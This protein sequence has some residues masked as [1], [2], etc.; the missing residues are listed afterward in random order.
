MAVCTAHDDRTS[1]LRA[2]QTLSALWLR[3]TRTGLSV[4]PLSQVIEVPET[5]HALHEDVFAGMAR[6]QLLVRLGWQEIARAT[7]PV[8]PRRPL[9]DVLLS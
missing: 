3:A 1:W 2:G 4:V 6:P 8:T 7:L 5:R 9:A